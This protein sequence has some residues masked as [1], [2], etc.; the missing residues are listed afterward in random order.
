[1]QKT[2][3]GN[4]LEEKL[5]AIKELGDKKEEASFK[6]LLTSLESE[7]PRI[8]LDAIAALDKFKAM[9]GAVSGGYAHQTAN[10]TRVVKPFVKL[11]NMKNILVRLAV[12]NQIGKFQDEDV[13]QILLG[14]LK[15]R[16]SLVR[17]RAVEVLSD[18]DISRCE[19]DLKKTLE[20]ERNKKVRK[21][22]I[23][24]LKREGRK[25]PAGGL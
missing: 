17:T 22:I 6:L 2:K 3:T 20:S 16:S 5:V 19:D 12:I 8:L 13:F 21:A 11:M 1:M 15:D 9:P 4:S 18:W 14:A 25:N 10:D 23:K 7:D 24:A